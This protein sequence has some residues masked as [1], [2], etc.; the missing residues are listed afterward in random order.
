[1][2]P[3]TDR[4]EEFRVKKFSTKDHGHN[5]F[6]LIPADVVENLWDEHV[7][8]P[9]SMLKVIS[10][11][12]FG[13]DHVSV[14]HP[15]REPTNSEMERVRRLFWDSYATVVEYHDAVDGISTAVSPP[16][17]R[18]MWSPQGCQI[19]TPPSRIRSP[20]LLSEEEKA[21]QDYDK[22]ESSNIAAVKYVEQDELLFVVFTS[23]A[24]YSYGSVPKETYMGLMKA[25]S[26]GSYFHSEIRDKF[27][28]KKIEEV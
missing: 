20:F 23:G 7:E 6:F 3:T 15:H 8:S 27:T 4:V 9:G 28:A 17:E 16:V 12:G 5:G 19:I 25:D 21:M 22:V 14:A 11:C 13:W 10:S 2:R 24:H 18:H 26:V 1:M